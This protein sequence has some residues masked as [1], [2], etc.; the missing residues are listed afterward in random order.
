MKT[1]TRIYNPQFN[2]NVLDRKGSLDELTRDEV[3]DLNKTLRQ[4]LLKA[5]EPIELA[6]VQLDLSRS[7]RQGDATI[8][9][10]PLNIGVLV[11]SSIGLLQIRL[12][13]NTDDCSMANL[14]KGKNAISKL[15]SDRRDLIKYFN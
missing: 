15:S 6:I 12:A 2:F 3:D 7:Q 11:E 14:K 4:A 8:E 1:I 9:V 10:S 5:M 13:L